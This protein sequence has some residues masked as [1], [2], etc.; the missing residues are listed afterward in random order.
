MG[1]FLCVLREVC[2][3]NKGNSLPTSVQVIIFDHMISISF[4]TS[5]S[6]IGRL[7]PAS[8]GVTVAMAVKLSIHST[9]H[10]QFTKMAMASFIWNFR[11][12]LN[13]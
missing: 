12:F 8:F 4:C 9:A 10:L 3:G 13:Q 5:L 6:T 11:Q 1:M 7:S 2:G